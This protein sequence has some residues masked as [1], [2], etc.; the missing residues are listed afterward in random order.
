VHRSRSEAETGAGSLSL[1]KASWGS[2]SKFKSFECVLVL[3][4]SDWVV[5]WLP[6][7]SHKPSC[8]NCSKGAMTTCVRRSQKPG[9]TSKCW[10]S[11]AQCWKRVF[12]Q[13]DQEEWV[14]QRLHLLFLLLSNIPEENIT[15]L[16]CCRN[17]WK[18][19]T[20][21]LWVQGKSLQEISKFQ[22]RLSPN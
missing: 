17:R 12:H 9:T 5:V 22:G 3:W 6:F 18:A 14:P 8:V 13:L 1:T 19:T 20:V 10:G 15:L 21:G 16:S 2:S 7:P 11:T 4:P